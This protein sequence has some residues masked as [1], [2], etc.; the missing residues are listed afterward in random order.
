MV[1][2]DPGLLV[3]LAVH[4]SSWLSKCYTSSLSNSHATPMTR[5]SA[6]RGPHAAETKFEKCTSYKKSRPGGPFMSKIP[7]TVHLRV[8]DE[9]ARQALHSQC[10]YIVP[11]ASSRARVNL[12][13]GASRWWAVTGIL[14]RVG[15]YRTI[16]NHSPID[17]GLLIRK[18]ILRAMRA[19]K[20]HLL[21]FTSFFK[22]TLYHPTA[23]HIDSTR[24]I[25]DLHCA[26]G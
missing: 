19:V 13:G 5:T 9:N 22:S 20:L 21:D 24:I 3:S 23:P 25:N 4:M 7:V 15:K 10:A 17:L 26:D 16:I 11:S 18:S 1:L 14:S 6:A 8:I 2:L 12:I